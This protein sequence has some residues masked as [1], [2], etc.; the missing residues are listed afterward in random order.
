MP[1]KKRGQKKNG[2]R[3]KLTAAALT[4]LLSGTRA[5]DRRLERES[6]KQALAQMVRGYTAIPGTR[7]ALQMLDKTIEF[8][9]EFSKGDVVSIKGN[10]TE[11]E[12]Y[13]LLGI[14][15]PG[16][17]GD[18]I[19][20]PTALP[21]QGPGEGRLTDLK[22]TVFIPP[23]HRTDDLTV[24]PR[25]DT[26]P[27]GPK[28]LVRVSPDMLRRYKDIYP[29]G[30]HLAEFDKLEHALARAKRDGVNWSY[31]FPAGESKIANIS[32]ESPYAVARAWNEV[33]GNIL[34][35]TK[36]RQEVNKALKK[37]KQQ[38]NK[39]KT[40]VEKE[41]KAK[42]KYKQTVKETDAAN[43][44]LKGV[45]ATIA[46]VGV[47][48][49]PLGLP[50]ASVM[51]AAVPLG[52]SAYSMFKYGEPTKPKEATLRQ[53]DKYELKL[54]QDNYKTALKKMR[55]KNANNTPKTSMVPRKHSSGSGPRTR[56]K[57]RKG[58]KRKTRS[59]R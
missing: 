46:A 24:L 57:S 21:F 55:A 49:N 40:A 39:V 53:Q 36:L 42:E 37:L 12:R 22:G 28:Q 5:M 11:Y 16:I 33:R 29:G 52:V 4:G 10:P 19:P 27:V 13:R 45:L 59:R 23:A 47:V 54:A 15:I 20:D 6:T 43:S 41:E 50:A 32:E 9:R 58:N 35:E 7:N 38:E 8:P 30:Q 48:A 14:P 2:T 26:Q 56:K 17:R 25:A 18:E 3:K 1:T 51:H 34:S 31:R 44:Q